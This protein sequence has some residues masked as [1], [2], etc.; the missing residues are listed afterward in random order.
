M[1]IAYRPADR[2]LVLRYL[3]AAGW[4]PDAATAALLDKAEALVRQAA[5]RAVSGG[6]CRWLRSICKRRAA[7]LP[8]TC[9]AAGAS[10]TWRRRS[11]P[12]WMRCCA[13]WK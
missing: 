4:A 1:E 11:A 10:F 2:R 5:R 6:R 3:G 13:A 8:A 9:R 7:T 12:G